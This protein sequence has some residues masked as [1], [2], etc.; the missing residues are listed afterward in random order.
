MTI[1][2]KKCWEPNFKKTNFCKVLPSPEPI[3]IIPPTPLLCVGINTTEIC[4]DNTKW[5]S[6]DQVLGRLG[7]PPEGFYGILL[8]TRTAY[9]DDNVEL[10]TSIYPQSSF[11]GITFFRVKTPI[12]LTFNVNEN[13][14][15]VLNFLN[16]PGGSDPSQKPYISGASGLL[17]GNN[18]QFTTTT[19]QKMN[20][21][22]NSF[23]SVGKSTPN[24]FYK[25][26]V[27]IYTFNVL[28]LSDAQSKGHSIVSSVANENQLIGPV[29]VNM[30]LSYTLSSCE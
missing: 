3:T 12:Y 19:T 27:G 14:A 6:N 13:S 26:D 9:N 17:L 1:I 23:F 21:V 25:V 5:F 16:N 2:N 24:A 15:I 11:G 8:Y 28:I 22:G 18:L 4:P 7:P 10:L 20:D 29:A 30:G